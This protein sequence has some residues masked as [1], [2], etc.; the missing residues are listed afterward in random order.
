MSYPTLI[1]KVRELSTAA[2]AMGALGGELRLRQSGVDGDPRIR[3]ALQGVVNSFDP[4]LLDGIEPSQAAVVVSQLSYALQE[5]LDLIRE[6][7]R[8]PGWGYKDAAVLQNIGH[9]SRLLIHTITDLALQRPAL[10]NVLH[11]DRAFLDV[12]TGVAW[13]A[14]EAA[15]RWPGMRV[16]GLD[17]WEPSLKL[18]EANIAAEKLDGRVALRRQSI[19]D[20]DDDRAFDLIWLPSMFLPRETVEVSLPRVV[21]ALKPGGAVVFGLFAPRPG[22]H[23]KAVTDLQTIRGGGY[24]WQPDEIVQR[25]RTCGCVDVEFV[26]PNTRLVLARRPSA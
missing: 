8:S 26:E 11:G 14:I 4:A 9:S 13:I 15:K 20:L 16:V 2:L 5:A 6:P 18:A 24:P 7:G 10:A 3:A 19:S 21:R 1:A 22:P 23:G 17:I 25:F 12:G